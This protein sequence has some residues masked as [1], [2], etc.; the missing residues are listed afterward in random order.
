MEAKITFANGQVINAQQ[1]GNNYIVSKKPD[2]PTNL[3]NI[4]IEDE[5]GETTIVNGEIIECAPL[6]KKYWF[7]IREIPESTVREQSVDQRIS[8]I[9]DALCEISKE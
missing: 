4:K 6:D 9:E 1:N 7:T 2:F 3:K 5:N 8:D